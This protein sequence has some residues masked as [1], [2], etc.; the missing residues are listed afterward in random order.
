MKTT[1]AQNLLT[2]EL[3]GVL[4]FTVTIARAAV[5][6]PSWNDGRAGQSIIEFVAKVTKPGS[7]DFVPVAERIATFDHAADPPGAVW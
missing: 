7:R 3:I 2:A 5:A 1:C 6:L 4:A